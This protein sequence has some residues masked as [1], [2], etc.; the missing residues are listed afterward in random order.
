MVL[1]AVVLRGPRGR[2]VLWLEVIYFISVIL[3]V[4]RVVITFILSWLAGQIVT[5]L[6]V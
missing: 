5:A 1:V 3:S 2:V 4:N 6:G